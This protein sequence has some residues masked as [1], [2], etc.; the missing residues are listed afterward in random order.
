MQYRCLASHE[1]FV[2]GL[3]RFH[4][5]AAGLADRHGGSPGDTMYSCNNSRA[6][7]AVQQQPCKEISVRRVQ[8]GVRWSNS[9]IPIIEL[10]AP[11]MSSDIRRP[12]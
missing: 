5:H 2:S 7:T 8:H 3:L 6:T 10:R 4:K 12:K 11:L 1:R 9:E